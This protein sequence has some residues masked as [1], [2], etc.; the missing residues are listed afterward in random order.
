M[1]RDAK[2]SSHG[3]SL[4]HEQ[5][6]PRPSG[7][8]TANVDGAARGN[9][10]PASYA[11]VV[12][13]P[14]GSTQFRIGKY[15]GRATN[16]VAEY[17]ALIGA[18]DYAQSQNISRLAVRSDSELLVRQMQGRYKVKSPDLRPLHE[19]A[20]KMVRALAHFEIAHVRREQ[21]S[22]ADEL[23][24]L[25]LD[26]M[27]TVGGKTETAPSAAAPVAAIAP[28]ASAKHATASADVKVAAASAPLKDNRAIRARFSAG[29]LHPLEALELAEGEIVEI[30][31]KKPAPR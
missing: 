17:Y 1:K 9:P 21:N 6:S 13:A 11:V 19:R 8:Y 4:F 29:A 5:E 24:N 15:L 7:V 26:A 16:N 3:A 31:I 27:G 14:D 22:E 23:A 2:S 18:L 10:G 12:C 28:A 25:A 20:Q 30:S